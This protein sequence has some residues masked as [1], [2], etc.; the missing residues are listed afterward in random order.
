MIIASLVKQHFYLFYLHYCSLSEKY[1]ATRLS[2]GRDE[3]RSVVGAKLE[4]FILRLL[5][6]TTEIK[7]ISQ[8]PIYYFVHPYFSAILTRL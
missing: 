4:Y 3:A 1:M 5:L 2:R 6:M 8:T 7:D